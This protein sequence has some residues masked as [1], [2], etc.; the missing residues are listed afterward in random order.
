MLIFTS[1]MNLFRNGKIWR[2]T[3]KNLWEAIQG[4]LRCKKIIQNS[5]F[6][7]IAVESRKTYS[8]YFKFLFKFPLYELC[9]Y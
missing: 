6:K 4:N 5:A 8:I 9:I 7:K 2:Q 3:K 1:A